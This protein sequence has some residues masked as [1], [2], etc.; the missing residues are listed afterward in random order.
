VVVVGPPAGGFVDGADGDVP[1]VGWPLGPV[2][3][4]GLGCPAAAQV[5]DA[6]L[7]RAACV[8]APAVM[9]TCIPMIVV[10][11]SLFVDLTP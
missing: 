8:P 3:R 7:I 11:P 1:P 9:V 6:T 4:L 10:D 5:A 2:L